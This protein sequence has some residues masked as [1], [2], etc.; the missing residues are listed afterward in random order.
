[1]VGRARMV[2]RG[3]PR[4]TRA[5]KESG[6]CRG[7]V[8]GREAVTGCGKRKRDRGGRRVGRKGAWCIDSTGGKGVD[9]SW[10]PHLA[11]R[12]RRTNLVHRDPGRAGRASYA[13]S[14]RKSRTRIPGPAF[15][16]HARRSR[17]SSQSLPGYGSCFSL[18]LFFFLF[19]FSCAVSVLAHE[20]GG[21]R[22]LDDFSIF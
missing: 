7:G 6:R 5:E 19:F 10:R 1:M 13:S 11:S 20:N 9:S 3:Q 22:K 21:K 16:R 14:T 17:K 2:V 18:S 4:F 15:S 8:E 12:S